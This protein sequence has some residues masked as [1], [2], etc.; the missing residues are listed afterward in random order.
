MIYA[1]IVVLMIAAAAPFIF[2]HFFDIRYRRKLRGES[3]RH[4]KQ[5]DQRNASCDN[6]KFHITYDE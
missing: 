6:P 5:I 2:S 1:L 4:K 3:F